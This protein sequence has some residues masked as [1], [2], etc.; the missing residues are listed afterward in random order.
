MS[1]LINHA[2]DLHDAELLAI[3]LCKMPSIE[4]R[5]GYNPFVKAT[6]VLYAEVLRLRDEVRGLK[7]DRTNSG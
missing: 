7:N 5:I 6:R 1:E 2:S 4:E 3:H